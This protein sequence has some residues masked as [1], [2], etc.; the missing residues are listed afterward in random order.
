VLAARD[1]GRAPE[2][3]RYNGNGPGRAL[4]LEPLSSNP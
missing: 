3:N 4:G 2:Q 1:S